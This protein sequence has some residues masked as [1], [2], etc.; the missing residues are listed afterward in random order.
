VTTLC[1]NATIN[2]TQ[3]GLVGRIY[4]SNETQAVR[5]LKEQFNGPH[6]PPTYILVF[7]TFAS[8][9]QDYPVGGDEGKWMWMAR[10]ANS[11]EMVRNLY[12][13]EYKW[14][15]EEWTNSTG[16]YNTFGNATASVFQWWD[17]GENATTIYKLMENG[18][19][20]QIGADYYTAPTLTYFKIP[21]HFFGGQVATLGTDSS[22]NTVYLDALVC[23]YEVDYEKYNSDH[24]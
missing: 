1:D 4:L 6:G 13:D 20:Y 2:S 17:T 9:G 18:K 19:S 15:Y 14:K 16:Q 12:A 7:T 3:I 21:G 24:K 5:I 23:L 11:S 10:I 8:T 22:G